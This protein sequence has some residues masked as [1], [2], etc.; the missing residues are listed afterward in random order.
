MDKISYAL[1][2]S[3]GNNLLSSGITR[4][5][6]EKF[7]RAVADVLDHKTPE[8]SYEEAKTVLNTFF[9]DMSR[10]MAEQQQ[11]SGKAFLEKNH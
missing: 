5:D 11:A 1:G 2:L 3:I 8:M 6:M 10:K 4:L 9:A 7:A